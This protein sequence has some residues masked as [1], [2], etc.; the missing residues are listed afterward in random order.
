MTEARIEC[1]CPSFN[2]A[3]IN[4]LVRRGD[5]VWVSEEIARS[6]E[7]LRLA[8]RSGAVS[9]VYARRC[10]VSRSP[11]PPNVRMNRA[12]RGG[13]VRTTVSA[14]AAEPA[15]PTPAQGFDAR[16]IEEAI[17]NGISKAIQGLVASGSLVPGNGVVGGTPVARSTGLASAVV[18]SE[19]VYIPSNLVPSD[20][21]ATITVAESSSEGTDLEA[22]AAALKATR[23]RKTT[24]TET[25]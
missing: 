11:P 12:Q 15:A 18:T 19:P 20:N 3:D 9:V 24:P 16:A 6:S 4:L 5:V 14:P 1:T 10:S 17:A 8:V 2:I 22:A 7:D 21:A 13:F 23:K 25:A